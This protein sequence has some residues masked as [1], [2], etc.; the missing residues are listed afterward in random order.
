MKQNNTKN[1]APHLELG[2]AGE[3]IA[4]KLFVKQGYKILETNYRK[5]WGEI[6]IIAQK[7][8]VLHFIEVKTVSHETVFD[9]YIP[10]ENVHKFKKKRLARAINTYLAEKRVTHETQNGEP[11]FQIDVV[12]IYLDRETKR[13][14]IR[15]T[16][17]VIL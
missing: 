15:I 5:K 4:V 17:N 14:K 1:V 8:K 2:N 11:E 9:N 16:E 10:E 13:S 6:D 7:N 3:E 12:A